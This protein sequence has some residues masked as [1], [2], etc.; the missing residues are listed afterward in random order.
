VSPDC[1]LVTCGLERC[2][3]VSPIR[4]QKIFFNIY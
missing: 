3:R 4:F 2:W 1:P